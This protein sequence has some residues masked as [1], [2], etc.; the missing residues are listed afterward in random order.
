[1]GLAVCAFAITVF[2]FQR[3]GG[4][5]ALSYF[6]FSILAICKISAAPYFWPQFTLPDVVGLE[7]LVA[8]AHIYLTGIVLLFCLVKAKNLKNLLLMFGLI[9]ALVIIGKWGFGYGP[10]FLLNNPGIEGV[11]I[12]SLI[13]FGIELGAPWL[14]IFV[15]IITKTST[16]IL[17]AGVAIGSYYLACKKFTKKS[18]SISLLVA[19]C[20]AGLG[21]LMQ[22]KVLLDN[23]GRFNIWKISMEYWAHTANYWTGLGAGTFQMLGPF[24][25]VIYYAEQGVKENAVIAGFTWLH[26]DWLQVLFETGIIGLGLVGAIFIRAIFLLRRKPA[27]FASLV[28]FGT[29]AIIQMNIH[30]FLTACL[31]AF[32]VASASEKK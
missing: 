25:Q 9:D 6:Y 10:Y 32:L 23:S 22:G 11:L 1:M 28:T 29:V 27:Y 7:S 15:C 20:F 21:Y 5:I 26:N 14:F 31:G 18:L 2:V 19:F 4:L 8:E 16:G 17:G 30:W 12:S 13:P 24:I 3:L